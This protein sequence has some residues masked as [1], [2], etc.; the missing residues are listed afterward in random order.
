MVPEGRNRRAWQGPLFGLWT[1][2]AARPLS[3]SSGR[4]RVLLFAAV[5]ARSACSEARGARYAWLCPR[6]FT[7][8]VGGPWISF[9]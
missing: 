5:I 1:S 9:M 3:A 8:R 2:K 6:W 4:C 7:L